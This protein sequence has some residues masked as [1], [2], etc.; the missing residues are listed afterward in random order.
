MNIL[1]QFRKAGEIRNQQAQKVLLQCSSEV[2]RQIKPPK[3]NFLE[4]LDVALQVTEFHSRDSP[5]PS[6]SQLVGDIML[7]LCSYM[8]DRSHENTEPKEL[9]QEMI[10]LA[11]RLHANI[12]LN[13]DNPEPSTGE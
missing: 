8:H 3:D 10:I 1:D 6:E 7:K 2:D 4:I 13:E 11:S 12:T 9:V 5:L